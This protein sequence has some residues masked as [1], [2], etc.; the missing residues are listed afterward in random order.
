MGDI[1][2]PGSYWDPGTER[3]EWN[4]RA[5]DFGEGYPHDFRRLFPQR[6]VVLA[7]GPTDIRPEEPDTEGY[8]IYWVRYLG[9]DN[10][11]PVGT[12]DLFS[13]ETTGGNTLDQYLIFSIDLGWYEA[14]EVGVT[15]PPVADYHNPLEYGDP[16]VR[17]VRPGVWYINLD[18]V[19][20]VAD[21]VANVFSDFTTSTDSGHSHTYQHWDGIERYMYLLLSLDDHAAS[22]GDLRYQTRG[23]NGARI[24][25]YGTTATASLSAIICVEENTDL[26]FRIRLLGDGVDGSTTM[27]GVGAC[28]TTEWLRPKITD[29]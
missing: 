2:A 3:R 12:M 4:L 13:A 18:L 21:P 15:T 9:I 14:A 20:S 23:I 16:G 28:L 17:F 19:W 1:V 11:Y 22:P 26:T 27:S 25:H 8:D 6:Y 10:P 5:I 24:E 7:T 29:T